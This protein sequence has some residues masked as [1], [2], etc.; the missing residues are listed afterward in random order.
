MNMASAR[1]QG[2]F[3]WLR[4]WILF[5]AWSTLSG[6]CLSA[7][8]YLNPAAIIVS[9]AM[10]LGSLVLF[11]ARLR[12]HNR[13]TA[14]RLIRSRYWT[15]K[16]WLTLTLLALIGGIIYTPN[17]YDYLTY[18][19]PRILL[20]SWEHRWYWVP[21][22]NKRINYSGT[23]FE[24]LMAPSF[25]LFKTDR[26]FF[27]I[28]FISYLFLP[29]LVFSV[30]SHL[31]ISKR[32]CWWWMW[33]FP[34]GYCYILQAGSVGNDSF[35]AVYFLA[36]LHYL[37]QAKDAPSVK[38]LTLSTFAIALVTGAKASNLPL[39]LP[40]LVVL[41][42]HRKNF[43]QKCKPA[44]LAIILI[45]ASAVSFLPMALLNV[46]FTGDFA[47]D[48]TN[49]G[50]MK[51]SNP[52]SGVLGNSLQ[53]AKDN[54]APPLSP[55]PIDWAPLV[56]SS[57]KASLYQ[58]FPRINLRAGELQ[59][60]E[61]AGV[62]LGIV[63]F[64]GV[65]IISGIRARAADSNLIA[66]RCYQAYWVVGAGAAAWL[67]YMTKMCSEATSR[68]I[69]AYYPLLIAG[70]LV[71]VALDGRVVH[72]RAVKWVGLLAML[73]AIPLVILSPSRPLFPVQTI[74]NLMAASYVP[75]DNI[76]RY[77]QIY[78]IYAER[79]D[80][81]KTIIALLPPGERTIGL[82]Q[83]GNDSQVSLW[84]PFGARNVVEVTPAYSREAMLAQGI[85]FVVVGQDAL[86]FRYH[87]TPGQLMTNWSCSLVQR[88]DLN[89]LAHRGTEKWYL[90][91]L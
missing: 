80:A 85:H 21:T 61:Q 29:G 68:L 14:G 59:I 60:E 10:F 7:Y 34:C 67:I 35:A 82:I 38:N 32:I 23:G 20:W 55:W 15:P 53:L 31:G 8:G 36:S 63:L 49:S 71:L 75:P 6:W 18:R 45:A 50:M 39:V 44:T 48:P 19:F 77:D 86:E 88:K 30:F 16:I 79:S 42:F 76:A 62:G 11:H 64:A 3:D 89:L 58:D 56:P 1:K 52:V 57:L 40:W 12:G 46:H 41:F 24:W 54:L 73:S 37:Y 72:R 90:L 91:S 28:N 74:S 27:L 84:R 25:V 9:Y 87:T 81:F 43:F 5:S 65:F 26:L 66:V 4:L 2:S 83:S 47:G 70:A 51:E 78:S 69:A 17:N 13:L 33:V 22:I